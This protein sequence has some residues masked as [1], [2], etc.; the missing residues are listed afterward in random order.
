MGMKAVTKTPDH[1]ANSTLRPVSVEHA[2][3]LRTYNAVRDRLLELSGGKS[4]LSG[5]Q[6][7]MNSIENALSC[8]HITGRAGSRLNNP[9]NL[10]ILL[11]REHWV[12]QDAMSWD[13]KLE[14]LN[15]IKPIRIAQGFK[16]EE[17]EPLEWKYNQMYVRKV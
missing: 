9:F 2:K 4:E 14:L 15:F 7:D 16:P 11:G 10:I 12:A 8:H 5:K 13:H 3:A 1:Y 17:Y 6:G